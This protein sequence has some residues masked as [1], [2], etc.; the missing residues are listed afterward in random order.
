MASSPADG[1]CPGQCIEQCIEHSVLA[2]YNPEGVLRE[3]NLCGLVAEPLAGAKKRWKH[4][5]ASPANDD[6]V[7]IDE[8][9]IVYP[10][11]QLRGD[12]E[13]C[14][15]LSNRVHTVCLA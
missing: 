15:R 7:G 1:V 6:L 4:E 10:V 5:L 14:R 13:E 11:S 3:V 9:E 8:D 2:H 12:A